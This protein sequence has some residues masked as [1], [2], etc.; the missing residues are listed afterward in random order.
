AGMGLAL[1]NGYPVSQHALW[2]FGLVGYLFYASLRLIV[3]SASVE[4]LFQILLPLSVFTIWQF[5]HLHGIDSAPLLYLASAFVFFA[6][7]LRTASM[8]ASLLV[9]LCIPA[10][11]HGDAPF[12]VVF[13]LLVSSAVWGVFCWQH[14]HERDSIRTRHANLESRARSFISDTL[15]QTDNDGIPDLD[16]DTR[17]AKAAANA[18]RLERLMGWM[19]EIIQEVLHPYSCFF[20]FL[21]REEGNLKVIAHQTKS[22]FFEKD[23]VIDIFDSSGI[24]SW[25]VQHK[26]KIRHERLP[27]E[28][29]YPEYYNSRER[30]LSCMIYPVIIADRVEGLLGIDARRSYSFGVDEEHL[31]SLFAT[32]TGDLVEAFRIYQQK[33]TDADYMAAFYRAIRALIQTQLDLTTRLELLIKLSHMLKKSDEIAVA[34]PKEDGA[35]VLR[36]ARGDN[37]PRL[38]GAAIHK[39]SVCGRLLVSENDTAVFLSQEMYDN[40]NFLIA[41]GETRLKVNSLMLVVL[42]M[43]RNLK[44]ILLLGSRRRDYF[45]H[46]DRYMFS[47]LAAQFGVAIENAIYLR[48]TQRL[49]VTDGLTGL[50]NH[51]TFQDFLLKESKLAKREP[52]TFSLILM[53][54]DYFKKFNDT[55][56]H[57]VGDEVLKHLARLL[58][59]HAREMDIVARYGGEEFV[60]ILRQCDLKMATRTA[61]RIRK[62]CERSKIQMENETLHIT[63]SLGVSNCPEHAMEPAELISRADAA[64]YAAKANGRNRVEIARSS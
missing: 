22:R 44:G 63:I 45:S 10:A 2:L 52:A 41:P 33:E 26:R 61:E 3:S 40:G 64:L 18:F 47:T 11:V 5:F 50:Y 37:S 60:V 51:R 53:D 24:L 36:K 62:A 17:L 13:W 29:Q 12:S 43:Q 48:R 42:P 59:E 9:V 55:W 14:S 57:Q 38:V 25:V 56:G 49:A 32:L 34:V 46:Q 54:I 21:D 27:R 58:Q 20:F 19:T 35:V 23:T 15:V 16:A 31:M 6:F 30:I 8:T 39:D 7:N 28:K 4:R 1:L